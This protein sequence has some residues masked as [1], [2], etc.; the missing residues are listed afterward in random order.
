MTEA[1]PYKRI[2]VMGLPGSGKTTYAKY[3][4]KTYN[5]VH[6]N[7]DEIRERF[8]DWD[9][10]IE[11]RIR[12]AKRM[13]RLADITNEENQRVVCD[14]ICPT[15]ELREI[16]KPEIIVYMHGG[17][18]KYSNTNSLFVPPTIS[19]ALSLMEIFKT[20]IL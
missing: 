20:E 15:K 3:F 19:E 12:Q 7:A 14:F 13:S 17:N 10:T 8:N 1:F 11:G 16:F 18:D 2:L 9:F 4:A 5:A 6:W